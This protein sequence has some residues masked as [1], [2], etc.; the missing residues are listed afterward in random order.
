MQERQSLWHRLFYQMEQ[1]GNRGDGMEFAGF[2]VFPGIHVRAP[3]N[4]I[5]EKG[6]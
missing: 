1:A 2:N 4:C 3:K 5:Q 6:I